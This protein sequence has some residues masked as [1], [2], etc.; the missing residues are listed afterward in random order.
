MLFRFVSIFF[1]ELLFFLA[2]LVA[3][4]S[5]FLN[6][7]LTSRCRCG[8]MRESRDE[9]NKKFFVWSQIVVSP[10]MGYVSPQ[11]ARLVSDGLQSANS[12][13]SAID[14]GR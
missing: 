14:K 6:A 9:D 4:L 11:T 1:W 3:V 7:Y 10:N 8:I 5:F 12:R 13:D 2:S